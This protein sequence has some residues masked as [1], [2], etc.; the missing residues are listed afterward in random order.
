[1]KLIRVVLVTSTIAWSTIGCAKREASTVLAPQPLAPSGTV[2]VAEAH[3][4]S[5]GPELAR[6]V[7]SAAGNPLAQRA[8]IEAPQPGLRFVS[9]AAVAAAGLGS[10]GARYRAT[11]LPYADPADPNR[12]TFITLL[13]QGGAVMCQ[14]SELLISATRVSPDSG[15]VPITMFGRTLYLRE[16]QPYVPA[17]GGSVAKAPERFNK[18][19]F[20]Q[21]FMASLAT[22]DRVADAVCGSLPQYP[23]CVAVVDGVGTAAAAIGCGIYAYSR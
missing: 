15:Y 17:G 2:K 13:E 18:A 19:K 3:W 9:D 8:L 23:Q 20:F 7:E 5:S 4:I 12:A 6:A 14:R 21:C 16:S 11:I 10:D 1:M 22:V